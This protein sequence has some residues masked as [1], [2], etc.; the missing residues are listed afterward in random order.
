MTRAAFASLLLQQP[1]RPFTVVLNHYE[2][3]IQVNR[4]EQVHA[5]PG[6]RIVRIESGSD[7]WIIDLDLVAAIKV[8]PLDRKPF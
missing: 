1:F 7:V 6:D 5:Q 8:E 2:F 3:G 4:P